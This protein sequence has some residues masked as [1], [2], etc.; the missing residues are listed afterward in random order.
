[1]IGG[2]GSSATQGSIPTAVKIVCLDD[3]QGE[4]LPRMCATQLAH[5]PERRDAHAVLNHAPRLTKTKAAS[6]HVVGGRP[7]QLP[8]NHERGRR[9]LMVRAFGD[10]TDT[11][12]VE[13]EQT[14]STNGVCQVGVMLQ[15]LVEGSSGRLQ[16][17]ALLL[18]LW[19]G[20]RKEASPKVHCVQQ[21]RVWRAAV[22]RQ[23]R[24]LNAGDVDVETDLMAMGGKDLKTVCALLSAREP[25]SEMI[26]YRERDVVGAMIEALN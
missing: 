26:P 14:R 8:A 22:S 1:V 21:R 15:S 19:P 5:L 16:K 4:I 13:R 7:V 23:D 20:T 17:V 11:E 12:R 24:S 25:S 10:A 2:N 18:C 6:V 3:L 9:A